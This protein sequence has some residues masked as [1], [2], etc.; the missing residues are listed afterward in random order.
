MVKECQLKRITPQDVSHL[1]QDIIVKI[2]D[3]VG[4][5]DIGHV[6]LGKILI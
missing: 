1:E 2:R 4:N 5:Q 3:H 6:K